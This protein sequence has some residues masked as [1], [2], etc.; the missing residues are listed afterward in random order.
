M[1]A[2]EIGAIGM[3]FSYKNA[4]SPPVLSVVCVTNP[5]FLADF[6]GLTSA[7]DYQKR[8]LRAELAIHAVRV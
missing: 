8:G 3:N 7:I 1:A 6:H 2:F 4:K 5:N